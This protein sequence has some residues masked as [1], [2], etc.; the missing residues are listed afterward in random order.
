MARIPEHTARIVRAGL[1]QSALVEGSLMRAHPEL[2]R[3]YILRS[4]TA[5]LPDIHQ[6]FERITSQG[7]CE[8]KP[9]GLYVEPVAS[10]KDSFSY[11]RDRYNFAI[12]VMPKT[13]TPGERLGLN[14]SQD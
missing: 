2:K 4:G 13:P 6:T 7:G 12:F 5:S 9:L 1:M 11:S 8:S 10:S 3:E 14:K